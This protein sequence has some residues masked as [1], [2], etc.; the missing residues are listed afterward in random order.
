MIFGLTQTQFQ[1]LLDTDMTTLECLQPSS[2]M[3]HQ[4][5]GLP[6]ISEFGLACWCQGL[7]FVEEWDCYNRGVPWLQLVVLQFNHLMTL[8]TWL[9]FEL[10]CFQQLAT[11]KL[12]ASLDT[13]QFCE[14]CLRGYR[15]KS[16]AVSRNS[17]PDNGGECKRIWWKY[18]H[19]LA[20]SGSGLDGWWN[21][22]H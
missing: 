3:W 4:N 1:P 2:G 17:F 14:C 12:W 22:T 10:T 5:I 7:C 6:T 9:M 8:T 13:K 20:M 15:S 18:S 16:L 19:R 21:F 11:D